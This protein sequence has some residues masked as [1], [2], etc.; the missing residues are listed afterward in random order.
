MAFS[1]E[2]ICLFGMWS[3]LMMKTRYLGYVYMGPNWNCSEPNWTA[4]ASV[5]M[6][7]FWNQSGMDPK[8]DLQKSG[9]S[10]GTGKFWICSRLVPKQSRVN[11]RPIRFDF[12][13]RS[14]WNRSRVNTALE[15]PWTLQHKKQYHGK[16][17]ISTCHLNGTMYCPSSSYLVTL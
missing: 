2:K 12:R 13:T 15:P 14:V 9:S 5:Y 6:G 10:F 16:V 17:L 11:R 4:S 1:L 7:L 3:H 8:L